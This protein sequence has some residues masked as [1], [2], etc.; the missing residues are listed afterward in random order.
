MKIFSTTLK[1]VSFTLILAITPL[2]ST[3]WVISHRGG[4]QQ[5]PENTMLAF[6]KSMEM[7]CDALELDVQVTKDGVVVV[8]HPEDLKQW[9]DGSGP[10]S[11]HTWEEISVLNAAYNYKPE[12]NYPFRESQ[13]RIPKLE[14]VLRQF[15]KTVLI[16]DL[17]SLPA[18]NLVK[19]LV[20]T[21]SDEDAEHLL[22]YSTNSEHIDLLNA[23]KPHWRTFEK[24]DVTRQ[25]LLELNLNGH[26]DLPYTAFWMGFELKR[27]MTVVE[28]FALG[29][30]TTALDFRLWNQDVITKLRENAFQF[31]ILFGINTKADWEEAVKLDVDGVYTDNPAEILSL[32]NSK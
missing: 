29:K 4:S 7:G 21:I 18:D 32:K 31:M 16:I 27:K 12:K 10:V 8:Y 28:T 5:L 24:R 17:K 6:A 19:A 20:N 13:L 3:P 9:T 14:D 23:C 15:E 30:G 26:S 22:F 2:F 25:R 11:S 1:S